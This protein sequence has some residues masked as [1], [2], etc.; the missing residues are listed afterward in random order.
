MNPRHVVP[1]AVLCIFGIFATIPALFV[2]GIGAG[3]DWMNDCFVIGLVF[4]TPTVLS[5][6]IAESGWQLR[7][8]Q[9]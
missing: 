3:A 9:K 7:R 5:I 8:C 2:I 1:W 6:V 4:V